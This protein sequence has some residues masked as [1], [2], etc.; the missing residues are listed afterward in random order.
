MPDV[1]GFFAPFVIYAALL[2]LH[3]LLPARVVDGYVRDPETGDPLRYRLNGLAVLFV[4]VFAWILVGWLGWLPFDWLYHHRWAGLAGACTIGLLF[5]A[6][7]VLPAPSTGKSL[8]A[9][10]FLGRLENPQFL[11]G[12]VDA[13][14]FLYLV[15]AVMLELNAL[16]F[17][18]HHLMRFPDAPSPGVFV[19][20]AL[21]TWFVCDYLVF[22]RVHLYTYDLFAERVGFKLGWGCLTFYPYFYAIGLWALVDQGDPGLRPALTILAALVFFAGWSLARGANMQKFV[23]KRDPNRVFLGLFAP[24]VVSDGERALLCSGFWG[25]SRH[26]NYLGEILM[27]TGLALALGDWSCPWPWLYPLYYVAL[28]V[29]RERDDDRRCAAKY[30]ELWDRYRAEVRYR[31][32]PGVY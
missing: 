15:G 11:A 1:A 16:S 17:A 18:A 9:D 12:R 14:M 6:W 19:H 13:K 2:A 25:V 30:G 29:P 7:I 21:L 26:V 23:F 3:L 4:A 20:L 32:I 27:A 31:I 28:L 22:E 5:T 8:A 24:K 10:L